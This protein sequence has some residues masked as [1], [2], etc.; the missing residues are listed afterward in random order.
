MFNFCNNIKKLDLSRTQVKHVG[1]HALGNCMEKLII[2]P[3]TATVSS[4]LSN[5]ISII[6]IDVSHPVVKTDWN[7]YF[8]VNSTVVK[9]NV[10]LKHVRILRGVERIHKSCF[11]NQEYNCALISIH[12]PA[13]VITIS[14]RAFMTC[15][16]LEH[17]NYAKDSRL[18][19]IEAL[20]FAICG[21]K[22]IEFPKM[23]KIIEVESFSLC[24]GLQKVFFPPDSRL[25]SIAGPFRRVE[26]KHLSLPSSIRKI[27]DVSYGMNKLETVHVNNDF[28]KSNEEGT[29]IFSKDRSELVAQS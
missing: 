20:A 18:K 1:K 2:F 5:S 3:A 6:I 21:L 8:I 23:L 7:K 19:K 22:K 15:E 26:I 25:E 17:V 28:F 24:S 11:C 4:I 9:G 12:I 10:L 29:A 14:R 16:F 13:S 27:V